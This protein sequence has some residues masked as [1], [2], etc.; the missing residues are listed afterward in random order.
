[1]IQTLKEEKCK[2]GIIANYC[3]V[4]DCPHFGVEFASTK[5]PKE[6]KLKKGAKDFNKRFTGVMKGLAGKNTDYE[7]YNE[8]F[9]FGKLEK[10]K[11]IREMI[12]GILE[13]VRQGEE[14]NDFEAAKTMYKGFKDLLSKLK[15]N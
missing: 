8:G 7:T 15:E 10:V 6:E 14:N 4:K 13:D 9:E 11:E 5:I 12:E 1:M 3:I 2:H